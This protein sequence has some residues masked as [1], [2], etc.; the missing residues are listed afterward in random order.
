[1]INAQR[2]VAQGREYRMTASRISTFSPVF[3]LARI[4]SWAGIPILPRLLDRPLRVGGQVNLG[5]H[6]HHLDPCRRGVAVRHGLR[7]DALRN[8]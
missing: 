6:R 1:M 3:A 8:R 4:A 7:L 5:E 2:P